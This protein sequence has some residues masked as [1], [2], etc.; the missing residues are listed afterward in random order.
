M[1]ENIDKISIASNGLIRVGG[2]CIGRLVV[3]GGETA[4]QIKD[5][6]RGRS[7][8]RGRMFVYCTL[9]SLTRVA[10]DSDVKIELHKL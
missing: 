9:K 2:V 7:H 8:Q 1:T 3:I 6:D 4:I 10:I 5:R